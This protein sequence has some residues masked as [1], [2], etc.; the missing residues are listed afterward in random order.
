[1]MTTVMMFDCFS[2]VWFD[3]DDVNMIGAVCNDWE[4]E[5]VCQYNLWEG[6]NN[7]D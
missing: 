4:Y 3:D 6:D 5:D 2:C 1:M 7:P